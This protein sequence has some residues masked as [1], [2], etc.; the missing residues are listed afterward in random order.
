MRQEIE[1][2]ID[3]F[4]KMNYARGYALGALKTYI[5]LVGDGLIKKKMLNILILV[6][7]KCLA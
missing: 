1:K 7:E 6:I 2:M 4:E 3:K 5:C